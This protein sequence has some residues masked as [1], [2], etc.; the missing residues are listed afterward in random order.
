MRLPHLL[1]SWLG[2]CRDLLTY[3]NLP[4][5]RRLSWRARKRADARAAWAILTSRACLRYVLWVGAATLAM[6]VLTWRLDFAGAGRDLLRAMPG[7]LS[8]P[9]VASSRRRQIASTFRFRD[10]LHRHVTS[11]LDNEIRNVDD[12]FTCD[13][14]E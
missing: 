7:L 2:G 14:N 11:D 8:L 10:S 5:Y 4:G 1:T 13:E 6:Y 9:W 3:D 12:Q